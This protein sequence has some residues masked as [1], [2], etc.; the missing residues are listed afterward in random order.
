MDK[1]AQIKEVVEDIGRDAQKFYGNGN[2]AAG[3]RARKGLQTLKTLA[4]ELRVE[5][6]N[7]KAEKQSGGGAPV[8]EFTAEDVTGHG[9]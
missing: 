2:K 8:E 7:A 9:Y 4:Q 1:L 3:T 5:I 6:Q